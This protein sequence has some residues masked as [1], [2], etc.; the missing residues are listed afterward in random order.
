M[1]DSHIPCQT[2][3]CHM[4]KQDGTVCIN[5]LAEALGVVFPHGHS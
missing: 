3:G 1:S 5:C 4:P 2:C